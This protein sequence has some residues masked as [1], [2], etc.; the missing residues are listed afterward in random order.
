MDKSYEGSLSIRSLNR[1]NKRIYIFKPK[2]ACFQMIQDLF[3]SDKIHY[4]N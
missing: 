4:G 3:G 2:K 1:R